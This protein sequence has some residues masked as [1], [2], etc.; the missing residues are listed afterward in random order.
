MGAALDGERL[1]REFRKLDRRLVRAGFPPTSPWWMETLERY[2]RSGVMQLVARVGRRGGKSSTL[3]RLAVLLAL[4]VK[5]PIPPGDIGFVVFVS[6]R[7]EDA[8]A[9]LTTIEAI[10]RALGVAFRRSDAT[11][12]LE[13]RPIAFRCLPATVAA[14]SGP[15]SI[16][17]IADEVAKWR[18]ADGT[19]NPASEVLATLRPTL[20]TM[21]RHGARIVLSSSPFGL[22]DAH[23]EAFDRG[24]GP[25]QVVAFAESWIANPTLTEDETRRLEPNARVWSREYGAIP[26]ASAAAAFDPADVDACFR[27]RADGL[28]LGTSILV[29]DPSSGRGDPF[30]WAA[31][32]WAWPTIAQ[33]E[34]QQRTPVHAVVGADGMTRLF[35]IDDGRTGGGPVIDRDR[36]VLIVEAVEGV[37]VKFDASAAGAV[38]T[39]AAATARRYGAR[40]AFGDQRDLLACH[41]EFARR[42]IRYESLAWTAESKR[43]GVEILRR[44][45][46]DRRLVLPDHAKLREQLIGFEA[47]ILP[48]GYETYAGRR[49][50]HDDYCALLITAALAEHEGYLP[51]SPMRRGSDG[52]RMLTEADRIALGWPIL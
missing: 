44:W 21:A 42:S 13:D 40:R 11:I 39:R 14:A 32:R 46:A 9:R 18:N 15:T 6:V 3:C 33:P 51:D 1:C 38:Y 28:V 52:P 36:A 47:R 24:D 2:L 30:T 35:P 29:V 43:I 26:S 27:P 16:A 12:Y 31:C 20:A 50:S 8:N 41:S 17:V 48:S 10:L 25:D 5:W 23:C 45:L 19:A 7:T 22:L 34:R 37:D 4:A 49:G